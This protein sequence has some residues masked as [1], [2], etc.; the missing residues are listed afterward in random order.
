M[1]D[2]FRRAHARIPCDLGAALFMGV[3][4]GRRLG[5][6]RL[7]DASLA[8][9]YLRYAG[10]LQR[11]T[12]YRLTIEAEDG[13]LELP[14]RVAREGPRGGAKAP[15]SRHYGLIFNLSADQERR[16]RRLLDFLRR[17][18]PGLEESPFDRKMRSY[19]G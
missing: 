18:P 8:G 12:P 19:W 6:G 3:S 14:F 10:E 11:G 2:A 13:P 5:E 15:S 1:P 9:A 7:I 16:L 17:S 4:S